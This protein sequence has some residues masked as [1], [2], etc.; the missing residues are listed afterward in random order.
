[1]LVGGLILSVAGL[2]FWSCGRQ[3]LASKGIDWVATR[4][5]LFYLG[6]WSGFWLTVIALAVMGVGA[7]KPLSWRL[8]GPVA[9]VGL[10]GYFVA[11]SMP[12][13]SNKYVW[14]DGALGWK[15]FWQARREP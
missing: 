4:E 1:M 14:V 6:Q 10:I 5:E 9:A 8:I 11:F 13:S 2:L 15:A 7:W 12:A 3:V